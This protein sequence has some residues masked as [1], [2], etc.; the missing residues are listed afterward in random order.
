MAAGR[1]G[2]RA[3]PSE[4]AQELAA[5]LRATLSALFEHA[6]GRRS[7]VLRGVDD[8][9]RSPTWPAGGP[10]CRFERKVELLETI[11]V[12]ERVA[13]VLGWAKES[14]AELELTER[15]R[16]DVSD[17]LEKN[18]REFLLRQQM[19][20]IRKELGEDGDEE[21]LVEAYRPGSPS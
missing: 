2:R 13:K 11:D 10:T 6:G 19:A 5:E 3:A 20:S 21:D 14:L 1:A 12:E 4:R 7:R 8:P 18:Q 17:G 16:K 15:I 9:A